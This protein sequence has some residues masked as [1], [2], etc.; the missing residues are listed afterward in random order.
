[1]CKG[2]YY[3]K[4]E[5]GRVRRLVVIGT[6]LK[7]VCRT[8]AKDL[9]VKGVKTQFRAHPKPRSK[10]EVEKINSEKYRVYCWMTKTSI[11]GR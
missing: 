1:M 11:R 7:M 9:S 3:P 8:P 2:K 5:G 6:D 10:R 4:G